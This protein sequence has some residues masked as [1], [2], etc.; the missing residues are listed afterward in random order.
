MGVVLLT[1]SGIGIHVNLPYSENEV[2]ITGFKV[3]HT[4]NASDLHMKL[5]EHQNIVSIFEQ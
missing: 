1:E 4:G 5:I 3:S 2:S